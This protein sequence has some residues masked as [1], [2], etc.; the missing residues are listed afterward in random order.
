MTSPED[1]SR[2]AAL[3]PEKAPVKIQV[4][5]G[6][7][8]WAVRKCGGL[9]NMSEEV[10][11]LCG[12][13]GFQRGCSLTCSRR[14][15]ER[16]L[17]SER[18]E[19]LLL[20]MC[21]LGDRASLLKASFYNPESLHFSADPGHLICSP[22]TASS[23]SCFVCFCSPHSPTHADSLVFHASIFPRCHSL[24][25]YLLSPRLA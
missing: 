3:C 21:D 1:Q 10:G 20:F 16:P 24:L 12:W 4:K 14:R 19:V 2:M 25:A 8:R 17:S 9:T 7:E 15:K 22:V 13:A 5:R 23:S 18:Q 6:H 11:T